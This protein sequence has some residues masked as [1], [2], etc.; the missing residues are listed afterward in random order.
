MRTFFAV[1]VVAALAWGTVPAGA[2]APARQP[3]L[4]EI[5]AREKDK[6]KGKPITED[7]LRQRRR[8]GTVSQPDAQGGSATAASPA[9]GAAG[10]KKPAAGTAASPG[11]AAAEKPKTE[12]ELRDEAQTAW[13]EKLTQAQADVTN[14]TAEVARLQGGLNDNTG[15]LYGP[16]RAVRVEALENAKRQLA[17]A[18]T[19]VESLQ[20]EGRR[21]RY[22]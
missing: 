18:T 19:T 13:R 21:N 7:D 5:A 10:D 17:A 14:W 6:K 22:R 12:D 15:T 2:D 8:G 4:G 16:G 3:S 9:P 1:G 20:E 11:P